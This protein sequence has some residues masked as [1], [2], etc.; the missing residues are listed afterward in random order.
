[1]ICSESTSAFGQ[2]SETI[3]IRGEPDLVVLC[4]LDIGESWNDGKVE[5]LQL[6]AILRPKISGREQRRSASATGRGPAGGA[7]HALGF[8]PITFRANV[9]RSITGFTLSTVAAR[10]PNIAFPTKRPVARPEMISKTNET[11]QK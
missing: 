8:V 2:P 3:P 4:S 10:L 1:M 9:C 6:L 7:G 5:I 11:H